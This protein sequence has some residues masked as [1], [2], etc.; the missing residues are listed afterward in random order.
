MDILTAY[1]KPVKFYPYA[2]YVTN[3]I[4]VFDADN[5]NLEKEY[6]DLRIELISIFDDAGIKSWNDNKIVFEVDINGTSVFYGFYDWVFYIGLG[7]RKS[8]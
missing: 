7:V 3:R 2:H 5:K 6:N 4:F 8:S 1:T